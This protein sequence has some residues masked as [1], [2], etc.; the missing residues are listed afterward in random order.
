MH[1]YIANNYGGQTTHQSSLRTTKI[2]KLYH[3]ESNKKRF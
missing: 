2:R 3:G 1:R